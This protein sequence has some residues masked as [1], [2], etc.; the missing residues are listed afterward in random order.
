MPLS[1]LLLC[2]SIA[3]TLLPVRAPWPW[4]SLLIMAVTAGQVQGQL[5]VAAMVP[6]AAMA[7]LAWMAL[8]ARHRPRREAALMLL[9]LVIGLALALHVLPG[10]LNPT[11]LVATSDIRPP[12]PKY[13]NFDKGVA[14]MLMLAVLASQQRRRTEGVALPLPAAVPGRALWAVMAVMAATLAVPW[15]LA[16]V[17]GIGTPALR[18][19]E[20]AALFLSANLFLTCVAEEAAFRGVIQGLLARRLGTDLRT[21]NGWL[22]VLLAALLFGLAHAGGGPAYVALA[23][24]AGIGYGLTYTLTGRI[25]AAIGIHFALNALVFLTLNL[26]IG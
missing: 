19:P 3:A 16:A 9:M 15:V 20:N 6:V 14:G 7:A 4:L 11:Y 2:L 18:W 24:L 1:H 8:E 21:W 22:P 26:R 10:F 13:L 5:T 12:T 23:T 17:G 25:E